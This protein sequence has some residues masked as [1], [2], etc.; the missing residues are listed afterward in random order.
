MSRKI[1]AAKDI[2]FLKHAYADTLTREL[3][4]TL[5]CSVRA[6]YSMAK[7]LNLKKS[8]E[9]LK[10]HGGR[11]NPETGIAHRYPKG[12]VPFNKGKKV[13]DFMNPEQ[14]TRML[15]TSFQKGHIP[16]NTK[17]DAGTISKRK[18]KRGKFFLVIKVALGKWEYLS[19]YN[20]KKHI[21]PV[22]KGHCVSFKDKNPMNC[23]PDNLE[24]ISQKENMLRN[25]IINLTPEL[26]ESINTVGRLNKKINQ[27]EKRYGTK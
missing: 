12:H 21:G 8:E 20:Y 22:P 16:H 7:I 11:I 25:S 15:K 17:G 19:V 23:E 2:W 13:T 14:I 27:L 1:W 4:D 26:R 6:V 3:A 18:D 10:K 9:Y 24:L 5:G